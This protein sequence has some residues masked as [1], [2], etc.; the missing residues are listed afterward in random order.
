[1]LCGAYKHIDIRNALALVFRRGIPSN[2]VVVLWV[3]AASWELLVLFQVG[4]PFARYPCR[5]FTDRDSRTCD[6]M[7][8]FFYGPQLQYIKRG[9]VVA[10]PGDPIWKL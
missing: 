8:S 4:E 7:T 6:K 5:A 10:N 1:M 3:S 9:L 2:N